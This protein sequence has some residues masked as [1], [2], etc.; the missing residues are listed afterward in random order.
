MRSPEVRQIAICQAKGMPITCE[1]AILDF[2]CGDGHR[3]YQLRDMGY[4]HAYGYDRGV[5]MGRTIPVKFRNEEDRNWFRWSDTGILPY[6]DE[7]FDLIISDHVFEHVIDQATAF[8][9]QYRILKPGGVA[10]H[11]FPAKWRA[12]IEPHIYVPL[13][14][15]EPFK[16]RGWYYLWALLGIRNRYQHGRPSRDIVEWN[17]RYAKEGLKYLSCRQYRKLFSIIPFRHSWEELTYMQRS[18]KPR[19]QRL[20]ALAARLPLLTRVIRTF[21][22]RVLFLQK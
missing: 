11:V 1:S 15:F 4:R 22:E 6:P 16:R 21:V 2:G 9:E 8:R 20:G 5:L 13:G 10:V 19:I 3:V 12:I 17:M 7:S 18:Y 14:G